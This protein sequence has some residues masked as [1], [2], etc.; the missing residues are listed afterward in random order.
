MGRRGFE[1]LTSAVSSLLWRCEGGV[2][3]SVVFDTRLDHRPFTIVDV[4]WLFLDFSSFP[5]KVV[6][7]AL[8]A[9]CR[10]RRI[11]RSASSADLE[12]ESSFLGYLQ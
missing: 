6:A 9:L 4:L 7:S 8:P 10:S 1:P 5:P 12:V 2:N 11:S 3:L